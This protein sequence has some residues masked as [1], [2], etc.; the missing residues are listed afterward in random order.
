M[1]ILLAA[2]LSC[3]CL[4]TPDVWAAQ[5]C[6]D[7]PVPASQSQNRS[8]YSSEVGVVEDIIALEQDGYRFR[9]YVANWHGSRVL[10]SDPL[11]QTTLAEGDNLHF[12]AVRTKLANGQLLLDFVST[13]RPNRS[14]TPPS[15]PP[16]LPSSTDASSST[17]NGSIENVLSAQDGGYHFLGYVVRYLGRRIALVDRSQGVPHAIGDEISFLEMRTEIPQQRLMGFQ[18]LSTRSVA[19]FNAGTPDRTVSESGVVTEVLSA[20]IDGYRYRAYVVQRHDA[21]LLLPDESVNTDYRVG[22]TVSFTARHL[23]APGLGRLVRFELTRASGADPDSSDAIGSLA[24][25]TVSATV[26]QVLAG[27][28]GGGA[29]NAYIVDWNGQQV[30]VTD[31]FTTTHFVVGQ[32]IALPVTRIDAGGSKRLQLMLFNF[33]ENVSH[34]VASACQSSQ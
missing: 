30:G 21:E 11:A 34:T 10:V 32:K 23:Q 26:K 13:E 20:Q 12:I 31:E 19:A 5:P 9:A 24:T 28:V 4:V 8:S 33:P 7:S 16:P 25:R 22:D 3:S 29:Y 6:P 15:A 14:S 27:N 2:L 17:A 18:M 1:K